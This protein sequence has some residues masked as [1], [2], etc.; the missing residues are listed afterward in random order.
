M[1]FQMKSTYVGELRTENLHLQSGNQIITDAPTDN[2]GKGEAFSPTDLL[3]VSLAT[4]VM[5][6]MGI[7]AQRENIDLAGMNCEIQKIMA[8]NP[9]RIAEIVVNLTLPQVNSLDEKQKVLLKN[10]ASTCPV[11]RSLSPEVKQSFTFNW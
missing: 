11:S 5:T 6:T 4:C 7:V 2:F 8:N 1:T 9:R 3:C 10:T